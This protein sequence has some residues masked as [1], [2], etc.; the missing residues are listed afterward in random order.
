MRV[1]GVVSDTTTLNGAHDPT[2]F[3]LSVALHVTVVVPSA[4]VLPEAVLQLLDF[5]PD[6]STAEK[7]HDATA[8]GVLPFVGDTV[9]GEVV[10]YGGHVSVGGVVSTLEMVNAQVLVLP[11]LSVALQPT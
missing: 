8:V 1:G 10:E 4:N 2:L 11:A 5:S 6:P 3:A 9:N 7:L